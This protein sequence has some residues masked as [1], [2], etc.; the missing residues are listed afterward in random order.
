MPRKL[1]EPV[2]RYANAMQL[3][4]NKNAHKGGWIRYDKRGRRI[5]SPDD[6][7]F[8]VEKLKEEHAELL[9]EVSR[10]L[11]NPFMYQG[12]NLLKEAADIGNIS[13]MIADCCKQLKKV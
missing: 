5:W 1:S 3:K 7:Q 8:L 11:S 10:Y 2:L 13:M 12:N 6:V 4:L 9:E